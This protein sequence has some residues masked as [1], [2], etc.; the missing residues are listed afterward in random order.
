[1]K[2]LLGVTGCIAAY[3]ACE[4]VRRLGDSGHEVQVILTESATRF[5]TPL[6]F[7][8]L[9][10]RPAATS[11][12]GG[13]G[14]IDHIRLARWPDLV[15]LAPLTANTM[16]RL[17]HGM[18]D[19]LLTT[20][21]LATEAHVPMVLAPA[22]NTAMWENPWV[23]ANLDGL[24]SSDR[25]HLVAPVAKTLACGEEGVGGLASELAIVAAVDQL[26]DRG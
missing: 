21:V 23:K 22:M 19:D 1:M 14:Q 6:S 7:S 12:W 18:A 25:C 16:A 20:V 17:A 4:V 8:V 24:M 5:V 13:D 9:S 10:G 3:K 11:L 15:L 26:V 2:V